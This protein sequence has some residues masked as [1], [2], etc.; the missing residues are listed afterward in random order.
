[1]PYSG[2]YLKTGGAWSHSA[3][4]ASIEMLDDIDYVGWDSIA[5]HDLPEAITM[6][7]IKS[8][9]EVYEVDVKLSMP[10]TA[11]LNDIPESEDLVDASFHFPKTGLFITEYLVHCCCNTVCNDFTEYFAGNRK[12]CDAPPIVAIR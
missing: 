4:K 2:P 1:M 11:L 12:K 9:L 8:L 7:A 10:F 3:R 5:S 6:D